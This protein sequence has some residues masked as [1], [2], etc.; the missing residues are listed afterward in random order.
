M[1]PPTFIIGHKNPDADAICSAIAYTEYKHLRGETNCRAARCGNSNARI[2]AILNR[3]NQPL[4]EFI[5]DVTPRLRDI[6]TTDIYKIA[7]TATCA[8]ALELIDEHDIRVLPIT[9]ESN[10]L[11]GSLSIFQLGDYFIPKPKSQRE[12][13]HCHTSIADI[14]RVLKAEALFLNEAD[15][16]EDLYIRVGA[17]DIRSFGVPHSD[18]PIPTDK[19]IIVVGDRYDIQS[20]SINAGVRLLVI[21]GGLHTEPDIVEMAKQRGVSLI[22]SPHDSATTAWMIR[23]ANRVQRLVENTFTR[24]HPD[25]KLATAKRKMGLHPSPAHFVVD[26]DNRLQGIFSRGDILKTPDIQ[27]IL[28]D[29][30]ELSQA[31]TG[32]DQVNIL[33][34]VDH[35][36]LG[37][38]TTQQPIFFFNYPVGSTCTII[39]TFY[40]R[41][42]LIPS[43]DIAGI[44]MAGIL[45]DTLHLQSPTSTQVDADQLKWL[46]S[47]AGVSASDLANLIFSSGSIILGSS[48]EDIIRADMKVY[49]EGA[50]SFSV[51]QVEELGFTNFRDRQSEITTALRSVRESGHLHFSALLVTD[52]NQQN[53]LLLVDG[54]ESLVDQISYPRVDAQDVFDLPGI[55][56]RKKQLIPYLSNLMRSAG[57]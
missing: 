51:S 30:N 48:P 8:E 53:S 21:T 15:R 55:V 39:S 24:Y 5:G 7:Q 52:I 46:E 49:A 28:V 50:L 31:V 29:H 2:D 44:M 33:E 32:A 57:I 25:E 42:Q 56:S 45:S 18:E 37:N 14:I 19:S 11:L 1:N 17:M 35:H 4:P 10:H 6:M 43:P 54:D 36:R 12:M 3:F 27:L 26:E 13:R 38:P 23:S 20:K 40:Q 41:N 47:I 16:L 22:I 34:I 9:D